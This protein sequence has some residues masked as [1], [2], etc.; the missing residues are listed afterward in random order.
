M[1]NPDEL[2]TGDHQSLRCSKCG[3][4]LKLEYAQFDKVFDGIHISFDQ[5]PILICPTCSQTILPVLIQSELL[6]IIEEGRKRGLTRYMGTKINF[7]L[8]KCTYCQKIAF[9]YD[10]NDYFYIPGLIRSQMDGALTPVFFDRKVLQKFRSDPDY[11][12]I[13][14]SD[15]Y[16][17]IRS[18]SWVLWYGI[19]RSNKVICWLY[20][21]DELPEH[22]QQYFKSFNIPSDHDIASSFYE[23][24]IEAQF[25]PLSNI[26]RIFKQLKLINQITKIKFAVELFKEP[27]TDKKQSASRP[28][29]WDKDNVLLAVN[30]INQA[31]VESLA[32]SVLKSEI[33][34]KDSKQPLKFLKGLKLLD[35]WIQLYCPDLDNASLL[36]PLFV[37]YDFRQVL[38][39]NTR[40]KEESIL[41]SCYERMGISDGNYEKLYDSIVKEISHSFGILIRSLRGSEK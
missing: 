12:V 24:Q 11:D 22:E 38:S 28:I 41:Q 36:K 29:F 26:E 6:K 40:D 7:N 5:L 18:K 9:E 16:G 20:D 34:K 37:L 10:I 3:D 33:K 8:L 14:G 35:I 39:H 13:Q 30:S 25:T 2:K 17:T 32:V 19:T 21:L 23:A 31:C 4:W 15:T 1:I 27:I